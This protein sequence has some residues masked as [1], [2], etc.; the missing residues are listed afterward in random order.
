MTEASKASAQHFVTNILPLYHGPYVKIRIKPS[1]NE[2]K[3][4][5]SLLCAESA[6]FSAMF[7]GEFLESQQL[8]ADLEEME[9]VISVRSLEALFQ[10]LYLRVVKFDV[11]DPGEHISA[12]MELVRLADKYNIIGL[13]TEMAQYIKR[14]LVANPHPQTNDFWQHVDTNTYWLTPVHIISATF[15]PHEHPVR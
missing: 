12:A 8:T 2:Y 6:V 9:Y 11:E 3:I 5:K 15:L 14:I 7:E 10:W 13:E 1:N 4:S